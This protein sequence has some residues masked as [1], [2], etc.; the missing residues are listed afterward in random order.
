MKV[1]WR[2]LLRQNK[3]YFKGEITSFLWVVGIE[4]DALNSGLRLFRRTEIKDF[5]LKSKGYKSLHYLNNNNSY[6]LEALTTIFLLHTSLRWSPAIDFRRLNRSRTAGFEVLD[7]HVIGRKI[8]EKKS[9]GLLR[10]VTL[11]VLSN[12]NSLVEKVIRLLL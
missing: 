3:T 5:H 10:I 6:P 7:G 11:L 4:S 1:K 8:S 12:L 9:F 2:K